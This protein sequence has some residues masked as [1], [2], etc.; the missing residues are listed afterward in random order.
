MEND[1]RLFNETRCRIFNY[2]VENPGKHFAAIMR[3][4]GL[5]LQGL[6][7]HLVILVKEGLIDTT[8]LGKSKFYYP[9][10]YKIE[11]RVMTPKQQEM[12]EILQK[13]PRTIG[14]LAEVLGKSRNTISEHLNNLSRMGVIV[15]KCSKNVYYW[16]VVEE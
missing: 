7:Y 1:K 3:G 16:H 6:G 4:L 15:R 8:S 12:F 14:E 9:G 5:S 11:A 2:I 13:D 10:G